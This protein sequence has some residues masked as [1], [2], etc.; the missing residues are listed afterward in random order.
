[1]DKNLKGIIWISAIILLF[2]GVAALK[3]LWSAVWQFILML[4]PLFSEKIIE[5]Y[6]TSPYFIVGVIMMICSSLGIYFGV[7]GGKALYIVVA[8]VVLAIDLV[9]MGANIL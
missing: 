7:K 9:S 2:G 6:L 5:N 4:F 1:M 3:N 8:L